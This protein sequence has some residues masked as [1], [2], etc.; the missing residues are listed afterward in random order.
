MV[1][2][3]LHRNSCFWSKIPDSID[4][5]CQPKEK[6]RTKDFKSYMHNEIIIYKSKTNE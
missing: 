1:S 4:P 6:K 5:A 3:Q 2:Q